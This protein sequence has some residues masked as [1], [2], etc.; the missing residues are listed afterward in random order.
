MNASSRRSGKRILSE[1][2][3][4][5]QSHQVRNTTDQ[6]TVNA[7]FSV[8]DKGK[9]VCILLKSILVKFVIRHMHTVTKGMPIVN[10]Y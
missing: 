1:L 6:E 5:T 4:A 2:Q 3:E 7:F 8:P 10:H 9:T